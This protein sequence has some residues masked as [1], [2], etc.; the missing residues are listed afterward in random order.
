M[1]P[2]AVVEWLE[3]EGYGEVSSSN[4][5]GGGC[6]NNGMRLKTSGE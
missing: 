1:I 4:A 5:V 2:K 3:K 6:I